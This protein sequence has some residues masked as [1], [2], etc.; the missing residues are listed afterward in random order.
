MVGY[1]RPSEEIYTRLDLSV[2]QSG[3]RVALLQNMVG[4][5]FGELR[6]GEVRRI[7]LLGTQVNKA[8]EK[9]RLTQAR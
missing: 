3:V 8:K 9:N 2:S 5:N 4:L 7:P 1:G 6:Y